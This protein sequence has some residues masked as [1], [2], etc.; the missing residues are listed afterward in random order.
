MTDTPPHTLEEEVNKSKPLTSGWIGKAVLGLSLASS[1]AFASFNP[2]ADGSTIPEY[3]KGIKPVPSLE[4]IITSGTMDVAGGARDALSL[5]AGIAG[6]RVINS[7]RSG[8]KITGNDIAAEFMIGASL[9]SYVR[10]FFWGLGTGISASGMY[11]ANMAFTPLFMTAHYVQDYLVKNYDFRDFVST[12]LTKP[13]KIIGGIAKN[14]YDGFSNSFVGA[15]G[16]TAAFFAPVA[17]LTG[18]NLPSW[19]EQYRISEGYRIPLMA[20]GDLAYGAVAG[21]KDVTKSL[22]PKAPPAPKSAHA[23]AVQHA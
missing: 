14:I 10:W 22:A 5:G 6:G 7:M 13:W 1:I 20:V 16:L 4:H 23:P 18:P 19:A 9:A 12:T 21:Q 15:M 2:F 3:L 8:E 17:V 11:A